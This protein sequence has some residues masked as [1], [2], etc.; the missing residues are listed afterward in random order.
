MAVRLNRRA[1]LTALWSAMRAQR[2]GGHS[3]GERVA[4]LPRMIWH[5]LTGRY[6]GK[7]R[8]LLMSVATA[9]VVS[10]IDLIPEAFLF[11]VGLVDDAVVLA[12]LAGA[13]LSETDRFLEWEAARNMHAA[14]AAGTPPRAPGLLST[15]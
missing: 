4:A 8:L 5:T 3:L 14:P 1:A 15:R 7:W 2:R 12:W 6:D 13:V 9:Y 10:P 11:V